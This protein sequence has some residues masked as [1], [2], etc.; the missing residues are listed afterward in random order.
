MRTPLVEIKSL[1]AIG[2][3]ASGCVSSPESM[4]FCTA[5]AR[6]SAASGVTVTNACTVGSFSSM[7]A[8][9]ARAASTALTSPACIFAPSSRAVKSNQSIVRPPYSTVLGTR[10]QPSFC[11]G[12]FWRISSR[13]MLGFTSSSRKTL[14]SGNTWL[15]GSTPS[16]SNSAS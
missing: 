14:T 16:V 2:T 1:T 9:Q 13:A 5:S 6:A 4:R 11:F 8:R 3:P 7:R 12:A 10:K 15:I